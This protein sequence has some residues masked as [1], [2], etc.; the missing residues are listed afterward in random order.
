[1][2]SPD[3]D[4]DDERELDRE[5]PNRMA[6]AAFEASLPRAAYVDE[7][8]LELE[9]ERC[10][11]PSGSRSGATEQLPQPGDF[12]AA[13]RRGRAGRSSCATGRAALH[14]HIDLCR[15]RG[16]RLDDRRPAHR[17]ARPAT[18]PGPSGTF[19]GIIRCTYHSWCYELD[20]AVRNAPFLGEADHFEPGD[21]G[22]HRVDLDTWGGWIFVNLD[23]GAGRGRR[24]RSRRSWAAIPERIAPLPARRPADGAPD[25]LRRPRQLEGHRRELQRVLPLQRRP[26]GAVPDRAGVQG[27]GRRATS[28]GTPACPRPRAPSRSRSPAPPTARRSPGS[29]PTSR[30][31]TRAS[32]STPT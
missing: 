28:T 23:A 18:A 27:E 13:R 31:A 16:S 4:R 3:I 12:L 25:R 17:P 11:G 32:S 5:F 19:K 24:T 1:M 2:A 30:C 9:R 29:T 22:L 26:P 8:F 20:G 21:F 10:G 15:H 6:R 14:A 7:A